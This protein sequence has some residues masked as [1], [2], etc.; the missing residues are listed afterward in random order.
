[1][2]LQRTILPHCALARPMNPQKI[3]AVKVSKNH[4]EMAH[5][6]SLF[7]CF[8]SLNSLFFL[9]FRAPRRTGTEH[10]G[11]GIFFLDQFLNRD[12]QLIV[13]V[14]NCTKSNSLLEYFTLGDWNH[15]CPLRHHPCQFSTNNFSGCG[16]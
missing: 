6:V 7:Y 4:S 5:E 3:V 13:M 15:K 16:L 8:K 11:S 12:G 9:H 1:M 2:L 14:G 10:T